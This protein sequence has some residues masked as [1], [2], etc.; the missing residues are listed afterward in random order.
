ML[1]G[2]KSLFAIE[3]ELDRDCGA[4]W[5]FGR[6]CYWVNNAQVGDYKLGT[7][8]RD[9]L[10]QM[11]YIVADCGNRTD[12]LLCTLNPRDIFHAIDGV[13]Y[14]DG[15]F[16]SALDSPARFDVRIPVDVFDRWK[17]YLIDCERNAMLL[18]K[19]E[20]DINASNFLAKL[21]EFDHVIREFESQ[22]IS[23]YQQENVDGSN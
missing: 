18:Y 15:D 22:L 14:G 19:Q 7:S 12:K 6:M 1:I 11:K 2:N 10:F 9:V 4:Q 17:V 3:F 5:L 21:G 16:N 23:I 20:E 13:L 8:L